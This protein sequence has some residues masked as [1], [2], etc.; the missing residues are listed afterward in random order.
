MIARRLDPARVLVLAF[1]GII[2]LGTV[3][4]RQPWAAVPGRQLS[5]S[6]ALFTATSATC[7]TGLVVRPPGDHSPLGQGIVLLLVQTG[8]LGIM[9]F[10]LLAVLLLGRR[11]SLFGRQ[12]IVSSLT[13]TGWADF[14]SL[15]RRVLAVTLV[16]EAVGAAFLVAAWWPEKGLAA[17]PW[18]VFHAVS[19]FCNAGFGLHPASLA[20][21]RAHP[22]V[23][24]VVGLLVI[25]GGLGF[26]PMAEVLE[27]LRRRERRP[28][29]LHSRTVLAVSTALLLLSWVG[30]AL[31]EARATLAGMG[32]GERILT[33][34]LQGITPRTAGFS[35]VDVSAMR[36]ATLVLFMVLMGIGAA[37]GSTGGGVKVTTFGV[38]VAMTIARIRSRRQVS[39]FGRGIAQTSMLSAVTVVVVALATVLGGIVLLAA[40]EHAGPGGP[41][42]RVRFLAEAFEV[43]S[44]FGTVGLST[45]ITPELA[46]SSWLVLVALMFAGRVGPLTLSLALAGRRPRVE[47]GLVEEELMIG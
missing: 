33:I 9:T 23:P 40:A 6:E 17:V 46:T 15:L 20:P 27:R 29:S 38:L 47:P 41:A 8:G 11:L 16:V 45:G 22:V 21:W 39:L 32:V 19:A 44:A 13:H 7:V 37:P 36:P 25:L 43:V 4:L 34:W 31:L 12:L 3:A 1:A 5:W 2:A 28:L 24:V 35:S 42:G 30:F 18:G 26:L 14:W 10:G